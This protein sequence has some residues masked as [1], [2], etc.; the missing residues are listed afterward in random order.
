M[1]PDELTSKIWNFEKPDGAIGYKCY[2]RES[3]N[4]RTNFNMACFRS[5]SFDL[6]TRYKNEP[7]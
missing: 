7:V 1:T 5:L 6:E 3:F 4:I 2:F